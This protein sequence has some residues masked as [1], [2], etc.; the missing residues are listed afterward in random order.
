MNLKKIMF[1]RIERNSIKVDVN[2]DTIYLKKK[3]DW[4]VIYPPVNIKSVEK[5]TDENGNIN[6]KEVKWDK[7]ALIFGSRANAIK[8]AIVG[9]ITLLFAFGAWQLISSFNAIVSNPIVQSCLKGAGI[10]LSIF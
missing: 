4:Y 8:T 5:A 2:G 10:E 9:L 6:W 1:D 7:T 3:G